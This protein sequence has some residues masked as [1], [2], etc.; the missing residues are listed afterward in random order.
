MKN[1]NKISVVMSVWLGDKTEFVVEAI[2]SILSQTLPPREF[3]IVV[4][5]KISKSL[6]SYLEEIKNNVL[7]VV[8]LKDCVGKM[9]F[10]V[11]Q[12]I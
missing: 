5:G 9:N 2:E 6:F 1:V 7:K 12:T 10:T 8:Y 3:I 4:D 11:L